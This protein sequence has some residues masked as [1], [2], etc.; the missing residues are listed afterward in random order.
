MLHVLNDELSFG[1]VCEVVVPKDGAVVELCQAVNADL[2][3]LH[4]K[5]VSSSHGT[6]SAMS[7]A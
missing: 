7:V 6:N 4:T 1:I 5:H 3:S 2:M